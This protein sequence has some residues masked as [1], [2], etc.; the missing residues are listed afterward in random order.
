M[1]NKS[2]ILFLALFTIAC[3]SPKFYKE[4]RALYPK[5]RVS[6]FKKEDYDRLTFVQ[7]HLELK[8]TNH[9]IYYY[10][11]DYSLKEYKFK[12]IVYDVDNQKYYFIERFTKDHIKIDTISGSLFSK[13]QLKNMNMYIEGQKDKLSQL[14]NNCYYSGI[15]IHDYIYE[16]DLVEK[17]QS[18]FIFNNY[19]YCQDL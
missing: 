19:F 14:G 8:R 18:S 6:N 7:L 13:Y 2:L 10:Q 17:K 4:V 3:Q 1:R 5:N 15:N 9:I 16:I 11:P 12:G